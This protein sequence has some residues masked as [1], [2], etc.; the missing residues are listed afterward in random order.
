MYA[1]LGAASPR[2]L[3]WLPYRFMAAHYSQIRLACSCPGLT[4]PLR[5][6][7]QRALGNR[8]GGSS[9]PSALGPAPKLWSGSTEGCSLGR[10]LFPER[11]QVDGYSCCF[12]LLARPSNGLLLVGDVEAARAGSPLGRPCGQ[13]MKAPASVT[14]ARRHDA[15]PG[16][17]TALPPAVPASP[18]PASMVM[19]R[20]GRRGVR[21]RE[22]EENSL[23]HREK[24]GYTDRALG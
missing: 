12:R 1:F 13:G 7:F 17:S 23:P 4:L 3:M 20:E 6:L 21:G 11:K 14:C 9:L 10:Y 19:T 24:G 5:Q 2:S 16:T 8:A 18:A 15:L 22:G